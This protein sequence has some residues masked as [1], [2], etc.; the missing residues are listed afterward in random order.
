MRRLGPQR[1]TPLKV[2]AQLLFGLL[3]KDRHSEIHV[4]VPINSPLS[5]KL[6]RF[7]GWV[8]VCGGVERLIADV[9]PRIHP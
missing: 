9:F 7:G 2:G 4:E 3:T 6:G 5:G 1:R 8:R